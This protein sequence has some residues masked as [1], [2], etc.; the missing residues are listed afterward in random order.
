MLSYSTENLIVSG[1][2]TETEPTFGIKYPAMNLSHKTLSN[3]EL[4]K[5]FVLSR[6]LVNRESWVM[7]KKSK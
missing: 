3:K 5:I 6:N 7:R 1:G 4:L 2:E